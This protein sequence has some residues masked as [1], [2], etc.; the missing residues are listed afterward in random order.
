MK[1]PTTPYS[2]EELNSWNNLALTLK[3]KLHIQATNH[4]I[5]H[6]YYLWLRSNIIKLII[7]DLVSINTNKALVQILLKHLYHPTRCIAHKHDAG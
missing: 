1:E 5:S 2:F 4:K 3:L 6:K 7:I